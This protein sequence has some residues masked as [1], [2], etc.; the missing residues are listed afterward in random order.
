MTDKNPNKL[1]FRIGIVLFGLA[2]LGWLGFL[3]VP[4]LPLP[5]KTK[6][7]LAT[8]MLVFAEVI[9]WV[10]VLLTGKEFLQKHKRF[11]NPKNW[12]KN[13]SE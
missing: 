9:F 4:F 10:A 6:A 7:I 5:A 8:S 12:R 13:K 2:C 3:I 11:L 1:M